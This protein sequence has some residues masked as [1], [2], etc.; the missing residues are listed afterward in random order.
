MVASK[1]RPGV[2]S[3]Q[4]DCVKCVIA[5]KATAVRA[6]DHRIACG[7]AGMTRYLSMALAGRFTDHHALMCRLHLD[8]IKLFDDAVEDL[9]AKIAP[10]V[11]A[12]RTPPPCGT[13]RPSRQAARRWRSAGAGRGRSRPATRLPPGPRTRAA[14]RG[15]Y[16]SARK[17]KGGRTGNGGAY[18]RPLLVQAAWAVVRVPGRLQARFHRLVRK[19]GGPKNKARRSG[20]HRDRPH[21]VQDR[22]HRLEVRRAMP[23]PGSRPLYPPRVR[24]G[25]AGLPDAQAARTQPRLR[26]HHH[27]RGGRLTR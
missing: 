10:L 19:F 18:I 2:F 27:P 3:T 11:A 20:D 4:P 24:R 15:N 9:D 16:I 23:G 5:Q 17:S 6:N 1:G 26:H 7:A 22:L 21:P 13:R 12:T 25:Q 14:C 8:R